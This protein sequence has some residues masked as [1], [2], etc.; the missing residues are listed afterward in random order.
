[1]APSRAVLLIPASS[2]TALGDRDRHTEVWRRLAR[3]NPA[4]VGATRLPDKRKQLAGGFSNAGQQYYSPM[5][6]L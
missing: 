3:N 2:R 1:M 6:A 5:Q 4:P